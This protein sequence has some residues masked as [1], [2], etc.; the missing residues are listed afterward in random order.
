MPHLWYDIDLSSAPAKKV[1]SK[2]FISTCIRCSRG[3]FRAATL[4]SFP[5]QTP[6]NDIY[7][8]TRRFSHLKYLQCMDHSVG[9]Q[10][11]SLSA[12]LKMTSNLTTIIMSEKVAIPV[13]SLEYVLDSHK[14]LTTAEFHDIR[15]GAWEWSRGSGKVY[16]QL[17]NV[18]LGHGLP[19]RKMTLIAV[20]FFQ[21]YQEPALMMTF[22]EDFIHYAPNLRKF[23]LINIDCFDYPVVPFTLLGQLEDLSLEK[24]THQGLPLL[25]STLKSLCL[26][27]TSGFYSTWPVNDYDN[28]LGRANLKRLENL[29]IGDW[30]YP[31]E[32]FLNL[33]NSC[34]GNLR[35]LALDG[36]HT[37][38]LY[39]NLTQLFDADFPRRLEALRLPPNWVELGR[40]EVCS[41]PTDDDAIL[42]A[43]LAPNLHEIDL[44]YSK[45]TGAGIKVLVHKLGKPLK[46]LLFSSWRD[47]GVDDVIYARRSGIQV[48]KKGE[49]LK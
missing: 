41:S 32:W 12:E 18:L 49:Q 14:L 2:K 5:D 29:E 22:Q 3:T 11:S 33:F 28:S 34:K 31:E 30:K 13:K 39:P 27:N 8:L 47:I 26:G 46:R 21:C 42:F 37:E 20:G 7:Y 4:K 10:A 15:G 43:E 40:R 9:Y 35:R 23:H 45:I 36:F 6:L 1:V 17:R 16:P 19:G 24:S 25:S 48:V 38:A 44:S